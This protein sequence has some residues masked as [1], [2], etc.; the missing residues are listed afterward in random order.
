[1]PPMGRPCAAGSNPGPALAHERRLIERLTHLRDRGDGW[2]AVRIALSQ[3]RAIDLEPAV[4]SLLLTPL[5]ALANRYDV[6]I[7]RLAGH[8]VVALCRKVPLEAAQGAIEEIEAM[9]RS[10]ATAGAPDAES[11]AGAPIRDPVGSLV[12]WYDLVERRDA[13]RLL[14]WLEARVAE[15]PPTLLSVTFG[16]ATPPPAAR[17][18]TTADLDAIQRRLKEIRISDFIRQ[19]IALEVVPGAPARPVFRETYVSIA[20]LRERL[21][22]AVHPAANPWLFRYL[23]EIL[24]P[25]MIGAVNAERLAMADVPIS[26][27]VNVSTIE[28]AA[29]DRF[30]AAHL[31]AP[32]GIMLE[33]QFVDAI[34]DMGAFLEARDRLR[35]QGFGIIIDGMDPLAVPF[36]DLAKLAP[37]ILKLWWSDRVAG[38]RTAGAQ[39][40]LREALTGFGI[41]RVLLARVDTEEGIRWGTHLGIRRF[42]GRFIDAVLHT[43]VRQQ[44]SRGVRKAPS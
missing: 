39:P 34:A 30:Q 18:P 19:Q 40:A 43:E 5:R 6:E 1:M 28:G 22:L 7:F 32:E 16:A 31:R 9:L 17:A 38:H 10:D 24:D 14:G 15:A 8:D 25:L 27:N 26:L 13:D 36:V 42:Q 44:S 35:A 4:A 37:D 2:Y 11:G 23:T 29:F 33:I 20:D 21:D 12:D 41:E 3:V